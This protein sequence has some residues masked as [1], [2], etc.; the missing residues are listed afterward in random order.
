[1]FWFTPISVLFQRNVHWI[2]C[3]SAQNY[4]CGFSGLKKTR[5]IALKMRIEYEPVNVTCQNAPTPA[6]L[7]SCYGTCIWS[8]LSCIINGVMFRLRRTASMLSGKLHTFITVWRMEKH[9]CQDHYL[10]MTW[11]LIAWLLVEVHELSA[12]IL[13]ID[14]SDDNFDNYVYPVVSRTVNGPTKSAW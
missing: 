12:Y 5:R 6:G 2:Y 1:M 7:L 4:V 14:V 9:L 13:R 10:M 3:S 11:M 8:R